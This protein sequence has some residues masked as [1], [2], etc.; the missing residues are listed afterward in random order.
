MS[1]TNTS[2]DHKLEIHIPNHIHSSNN[3]EDSPIKGQLRIL[4]FPKRTIY[5]NSNQSPPRKNLPSTAQLLTNSSPFKKAYRQHI[6]SNNYEIFEQKNFERKASELTEVLQ[7]LER[8]KKPVL[9]PV[10]LSPS[11]QRRILSP[12]KNSASQNATFM[13]EDQGNSSSGSIKGAN[14]IHLLPRNHSKPSLSPLRPLELQTKSS[15]ALERKMSSFTLSPKII[16]SG[17]S[18]NS[19]PKFD[20]ENLEKKHKHSNVNNYAV[21]YI[22]RV[23]LGYKKGRVENFMDYSKKIKRCLG[24]NPESPRDHSLGNVSF[25]NIHNISV[26]KDHHVG[27]ALGQSNS[28]KELLRPSSKILMSLQALGEGQIHSTNPTSPGLPS[29]PSSKKLI[30]NE[31]AQAG[32]MKKVKSKQELDQFKP[33]QEQLHKIYY[34]CQKL[35]S[36]ISNIDKKLS[37]KGNKMNN[38]YSSLNK[39]LDHVINSNFMPG[40]LIFDEGI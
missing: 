36:K 15:K 39:K 23:G 1:S 21:G 30:V 16:R 25:P 9:K 40:E 20:T 19:P 38:K 26:N 27:V 6:E 32:S 24:S 29:S 4:D 13:Q 14:K 37:S 10:T 18:N 5:R 33:V 12:L 34:S 11:P 8:L 7:I 31:V 2:S 35:Q 22:Y 3:I 28:N 17:G